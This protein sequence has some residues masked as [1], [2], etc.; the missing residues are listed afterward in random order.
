MKKM[1]TR[2]ALLLAAILTASMLLAGCHGSK[3]TAAFAVPETL[4]TSRDFE[5]TFWAKNDTNKTQTRIYENAIKCFEA[6]YP[7]IHVNMRLYT[8]YGKIYN[9]VITNIATQTTPNV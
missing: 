6:L 9:D 2:L 8:D 3:D 5:I 4:D 7:N 1:K